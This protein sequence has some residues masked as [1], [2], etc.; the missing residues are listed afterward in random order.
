MKAQ[1][2]L[3]CLLGSLGKNWSPW[4]IHIFGWILF[5]PGCQPK[6]S[7]WWLVTPRSHLYFFS[8]LLWP[9][10]GLCSF[11]LCGCLMSQGQ[12]LNVP[13]LL[14]SLL[15]LFLLDHSMHS[16]PSCR[17]QLFAFRSSCHLGILIQITQ[18]NTLVTS[19][20]MHPYHLL[21]VCVCGLVA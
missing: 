16:I 7:H 12:Q 13:L 5:P 2:M 20:S 15:I 18:H 17:R 11:L 14:R 6:A 3:H 8:G 4:I 9:P 1:A 10:N 21:R 19:A